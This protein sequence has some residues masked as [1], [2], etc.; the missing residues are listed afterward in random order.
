M[1]CSD[2]LLKARMVRKLVVETAERNIPVMSFLDSS[3]S[4]CVGSL[5]IVSYDVQI[6]LAAV[7][8]P[9]N[10]FLAVGC[11]ILGV[12]IMDNA[13]PIESRPFKGPTAFILGNEALLPCERQQPQETKS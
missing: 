11:S 2:L 3:I 7:L 13:K 12:E 4:L 5:Q 8:N 9:V 1:N 6:L 10:A